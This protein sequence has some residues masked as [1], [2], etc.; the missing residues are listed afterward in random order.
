MPE[1]LLPELGAEVDSDAE[2]EADLVEEEDWER[3]LESVTVLPEV[4]EAEEPVVVVALALM[5][6]VMEA[7]ELVAIEPD[8]VV[9]AVALPV[10][11]TPATDVPTAL[12]MPKL[13]EKLMLLGL[14]LSIIS[15]VY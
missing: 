15:M 10:A 11:V 6:E 9:K 7:V 5:P 1:A 13:G 2:A 12:G 4:S 3:L 14:L 8:A